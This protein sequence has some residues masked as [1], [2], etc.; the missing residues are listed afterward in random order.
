MISE[1]E[2]ENLKNKVLNNKRSWGLL[3][4]KLKNLIGNIETLRKENERLKESLKKSFLIRFQETYKGFLEIQEKIKESLEKIYEKTHNKLKKALENEKRVY[5]ENLRHL[6]EK[7]QENESIFKENLN[8]L[9]R[10]LKDSQENLLKSQEEKSLISNKFE[11]FSRISAESLKNLDIRYEASE[12]DLIKSHENIEKLKENLQK[13]S[14]KEIKAY[15]EFQKLKKAFSELHEKHQKVYEEVSQNIEKLKEN[16]HE[17]IRQLSLNYEEIIETLQGQNKKSDEFQ[18]GLKAHIQENEARN[19]ILEKQIMEINGERDFLQGE[20]EGLAIENEKLKRSLNRKDE[21]LGEFNKKMKD[22]EGLIKEKEYKIQTI[23]KEKGV[24]EENLKEMRLMFENLKEERTLGEIK[25][26][27][28]SEDLSSGIRK[29]EFFSIRS[30]RRRKTPEKIEIGEKESRKNHE[31]L[32]S[33][34]E[35]KSL[36]NKME[37]SFEKKGHKSGKNHRSGPV[38]L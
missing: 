21:E 26:M 2:K 28:E 6:K 23:Y 37:N 10:E 8:N 11:E 34:N 14:E 19:E 18:E 16:Q 12:K 4:R 17:E 29:D 38:N 31:L 15:E 22:F 3:K 13:A 30:I 27:K 5:E 25:E 24:K 1:K 33:L 9:N 32:R 20:Y 36:G 35:L 7:Y